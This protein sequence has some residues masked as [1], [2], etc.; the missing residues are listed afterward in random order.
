MTMILRKTKLPDC[1]VE[2]SESSSP[3]THTIH[4][5]REELIELTKLDKVS[6]SE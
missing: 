6:Y 4:K 3:G 2:I 5:H 1:Y